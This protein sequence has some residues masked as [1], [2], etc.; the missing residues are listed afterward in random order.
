MET[1]EKGQTVT[2]LFPFR[3][4]GDTYDSR[5]IINLWS[6]DSADEG[7]VIQHNFHKKRLYSQFCLH[8]SRS[9]LRILLA[10]GWF[11]PLR[12]C[13]ITKDITGGG[14]VFAIVYPHIHSFQEC[15]FEMAGYSAVTPKIQ[16]VGY[17]NIYL[18]CTF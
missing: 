2:L 16:M 11:S 3:T 15:S 18:H 17:K 12:I 10:E 4:Y 13:V 6:F 8:S 14:R 5:G 7:L 9:V 1:A